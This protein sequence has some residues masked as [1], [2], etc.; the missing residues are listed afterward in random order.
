MGLKSDLESEVASIFRSQWAVDEGRVVP[1]DESVRL[2]NHA[3]KIDATVLYADM[4]DST[5]LVD[6]YK[7][8]FAAE[9]YKTFL[10]CAAKIIK[11]EHGF[12]TAYDG[13]R[14]MAVYIGK[15]KNTSAVRSGLKIYDAVRNIINPALK[16]QYPNDTYMVKHVVG[17]DTSQL[18]VARTGVRGANDLVW[19]GRAANYAAKLCTLSDDYPTRITADVYKNLNN[20]VTTSL[21]GQ[22]M[23]QSEAW[24]TMGYQTT[25]KSN[26]WWMLT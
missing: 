15:S 21:D 11:A 19:V 17:I 24:S 18:H 6:G 22:H 7:P 3:I 14:I 4:S 20:E 13:D 23:W 26:F 2:G 10:L 8:F 9:I 1:S 5:K 25:Y 12:I 16:V